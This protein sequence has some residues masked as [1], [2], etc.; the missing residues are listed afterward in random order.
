[1]HQKFP[2]RSPEYLSLESAVLRRINSAVQIIF[3]VQDSSKKHWQV[4][5]RDLE[6][7]KCIQTIQNIMMMEYD[8]TAL[9]PNSNTRL[10]TCMGD[11]D[12][13]QFDSN[14][15]LINANL[16]NLSIEGI[17]LKDR[18]WILRNGRPLIWLPPD[19]RPNWLSSMSKPRFANTECRIAIA[20]S[21]GHLLTMEFSNEESQYGF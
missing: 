10:H 7:G 14:Q 21:S 9:A 19:Y 20:C 18:E 11:I 4:D 6:T 13:D 1:M 8:V 2:T 5:I 15:T 3:G 12:F 16:E 17:G